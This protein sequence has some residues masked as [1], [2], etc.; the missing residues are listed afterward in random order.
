MKGKKPTKGGIFGKPIHWNSVFFIVSLFSLGAHPGQ[1]CSW[2]SVTEVT[3]EQ[4]F[5][6]DLLFGAEKTHMYEPI[7]E[8]TDPCLWT[9]RP[10]NITD[11]L[12]KKLKQIQNSRGQV[13]VFTRLPQ[14]ILQSEVANQASQSLYKYKGHALLLDTGAST[15][16]GGAGTA[17]AFDQGFLRVWE[18][19]IQTEWSEA[20][21]S[22]VGGA[23]AVANT[24]AHIPGYP[25]RG[26]GRITYSAH[27]MGG[28]RFQ[29]PSS[30]V[31][32]FDEAEPIH[33]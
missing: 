29:S 18:E 5:P 9:A 16:L 25:G 2:F 26:L 24:L 22:G 8:D 21:F 20:S 31:L 1:S 32:R 28:K 17:R 10:P 33:S 4:I 12:D 19:R 27:L 14:G 15:N 23:D 13:F 30:L 6:F 3:D 7:G 11:D